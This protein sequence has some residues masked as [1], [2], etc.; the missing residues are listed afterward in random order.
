[1]PSHAVTATGRVAAGQL[2]VRHFSPRHGPFCNPMLAL[3]RIRRFSRDDQTQFIDLTRHFFRRL[4]DI[5]F[6]SGEAEA[7]LGVVHVLTLLAFP[8]VYYAV[9]KFMNYTHDSWQL[10]PA[11]YSADALSDQSLYVFF[12]MVVIG[13]VAV[14]EWD[15]LFP[16]GRDYANLMPLPLKLRTIFFAKIASLFQFIGLFI[17]AVAGVPV[18]IYPLVFS[19]GLS[20][21]PSF[22]HLVW[23]MVVHGIAVF[24]GCLFMF[25]FFVALQGVLINLLT[26]TQFRR[27]SLYVQGLASVALVCLFFLLPLIPKL[28]PAWEK[29]H[30]SWPY[31]LPPMWFLGLYQT[32]L[33]THNP[34]FLSPTRISV[35]AFVLSAGVA[36]VTYFMAYRRHSQMTFESPGEGCTSHFGIASLL[37]WLFDRFWL[38]EGPERGTFY[39]VLKTLARSTKQRLYFVG[40]VSVALALVLAGIL[41]AMV[42]LAHGRLWASITQPD[43]GLLSIPLVVSFFSLVGMRAVFEFPAEL[44]ANWI[45]QITEESNGRM[46]LAG[47]RKAMIA[48]AIVPPFVVSFAVYA[49]LWGPLASLL[50]VLFGVFLCLILT[51]LLLYSSRKIP[52]TC[53]NVPGKTSLSLIG[54][55]GCAVFGFCAYA[56]AL[57]EK[58]LFQEPTVWIV[59]LGVELVI[60]NRIMVHRN[61]SFTSGLGVQYEDKPLPAVQT[62]DLNA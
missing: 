20:P 59:A 54:A 40:Y 9:L 1:M 33:G 21:A 53:S 23:M 13:V 39:F 32:L 29:T 41:E 27:I 36:V 30:S 12:S 3:L 46:C 42:Y 8:G 26:Y 25:L 14:L 56:M 2:W 31:A 10:T 55:M 22:Q 62:L 28:L 19:E 15:R 5:E 7:H 43:G 47:A 52:F 51:E 16:D 60:L 38:K 6:I 37:G 18:L 58:R 57:L 35:I 17:L 34:V 45:F 50:S 24:S 49:E 44:P 11:R 61:R 48:V 4:F